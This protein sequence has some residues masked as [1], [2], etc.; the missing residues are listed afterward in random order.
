MA[1]FGVV[2]TVTECVMSIFD[3][4]LES[5]VESVHEIH[6]EKVLGD[7]LER[8]LRKVARTKGVPVSSRALE[9]LGIDINHATDVEQIPVGAVNEAIKAELRQLLQVH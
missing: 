3:S 5:L 4:E 7:A 9:F 1:A 2:K 6:G 8:A